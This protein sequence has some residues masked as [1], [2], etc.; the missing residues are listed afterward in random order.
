MFGSPA[1]V[2]R[3]IYR[4][5]RRTQMCHSVLVTFGGIPCHIPHFRL[6]IIEELRFPLVSDTQHC[7]RECL[8]GMHDRQHGIR[9][10]GGIQRS[11]FTSWMVSA[12]LPRPTVGV[13]WRLRQVM[14]HDVL[15]TVAPMRVAIWLRGLPEVH[16][17]SWRYGPA[18]R[19]K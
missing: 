8:H 6:D 4:G 16:A 13:H 15:S 9:I 19:G 7:A 11:M 12:R 18:S 5:V 14:F 2:A 10:E 3:C 1:V 17:S